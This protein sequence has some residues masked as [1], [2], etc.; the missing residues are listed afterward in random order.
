MGGRSSVVIALLRRWPRVVVF[1]VALLWLFALEERFRNEAK[2][3]LY[4]HDWTSEYMMQTVSLGDLRVEPFKSLWYNHIQPPVFDAIRASIAAF[5]PNSNGEALMRRVDQRLYVLWMFV[6]SASA[7]LVFSWIRRGI[8]VGA[9]ITS[10]LIYLLLPGPIFYATFL[11]STF[12]SSVLILW[13]FATLWR[14][15]QGDPAEKEL[16]L[17]GILLFFTRSVFQWPFL[18][19]L[20]TTLA[21]MGVPR[22]KVKR[23]L[24]PLGIVMA[25]FLA[26]QY[27]LFGLTT[28]SSFGPDSFCKGLSEYCHGTTKVDLPKTTDKFNA[29]VLRRAE[30]LNGE[31]NYNQEAFLQRSFSQMA[32]YKALLRRLTPARVIE[33]LRVN[34]DFY[35]RPTSRHSSHVIVDRLPW[36]RPFETLLSG[37]PFVALLGLA[38][39]GWLRSVRSEA[40]DE[41]RRSVRRGLGLALPALYIAAVT[42][43][44]ESGENMRYRFFLEPT[45]FV[46]I[47]FGLSRFFPAAAAAPG[48]SA[49]PGPDRVPPLVR[50]NGC[51]PPRHR[52][53]RTTSTRTSPARRRLP[54]PGTRIPE[55]SPWRRSGSS[56]RPGRWSDTSIRSA[57][58][59]TT[60][61]ARSPMNP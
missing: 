21:L 2:E 43:V 22:T 61:R 30:K 39:V 11:D 35:L 12:L 25:A 23:V 8:G 33:I 41:R 57:R 40:G 15:G 20:A 36:R 32:E 9:A 10:V 58:W 50:S 14:L 7:V 45:F 1:A 28:T 16:A 19:V 13:F 31:Y 59:A 24:L 47:L 42:I 38:A 53:N 26:K 55:C 17:V 3:H 52:S 60:S 27:I 54:R 6:Y 4:F 44:F 48:P 49:S 37:W 29:F 56:E 51:E 46:F 5:F 18:V 34:F